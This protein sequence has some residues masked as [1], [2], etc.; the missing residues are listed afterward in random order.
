MIL[1]GSDIP[2][3]HIC[4]T[5][6]SLV[7]LY[8]TIMEGVGRPLDSKESQTLPGRSLFE[9]AGTEY[10]PQR[11]AFSEYHAVG[12]PS[13]A[14]MLRQGH[15]KYNYYVGFGPELFDLKRDPLELHNLV[16][17]I[18]HTDRVQ[19]FEKQLRE[20]LDPEAIDKKARADQARLVEEFGGVERALSSG[21]KAETPP[22][23]V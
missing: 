5:P 7:D 14:F 19:Y 16:P 17:E 2:E 3:D 10:D 13:G 18:S 9:F 11:I 1:A 6:V 22:P 8:P 15:F 23:K 21:T 12:A 20:L 4:R